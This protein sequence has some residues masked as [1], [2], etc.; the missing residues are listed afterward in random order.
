MMEEEVLTIEGTSGEV[1][2]SQLDLD[3]PYLVL[4]KLMEGDI[5]KDEVILNMG[6]KQF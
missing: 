2:V 6:W 1:K 3:V 4:V 5:L